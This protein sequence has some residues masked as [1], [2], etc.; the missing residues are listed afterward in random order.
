MVARRPREANM[1]SLRERDV[2]A[3]ASIIEIADD[4]VS[5]PSIEPVDNASRR[6]N[7]PSEPDQDRDCDQSASK[8]DGYADRWAGHL[9]KIANAARRAAM[10][11]VPTPGWSELIVIAKGYLASEVSEL[12]RIH[13]NLDDS[14]Q[15]ARMFKLTLRKELEPFIIG[16]GQV[17]CRDCPEGIVIVLADNR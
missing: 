2:S 4:G 8:Y 12:A 15:A 1:S 6:A 13:L 10:V 17:T 5:R 9:H 14:E 7:L 3:S 16:V 11:A